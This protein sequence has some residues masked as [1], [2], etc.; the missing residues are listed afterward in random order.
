M[1]LLLQPTSIS[2]QMALGP[3]DPSCL[4]TS[5]PR[6]ARG[7]LCRGWGRTCDTS[8]GVQCCRPCPTSG[9]ARLMLKGKR[10]WGGDI[11]GWVGGKEG[12]GELTAPLQP[13]RVAWRCGWTCSPWTCQRPALPLI[14]P[15]G[16]RRSKKPPSQAAPGK[17]QAGMERW[18][19]AYPCS[20]MALCLGTPTTL[21]HPRSQGWKHRVVSSPFRAAPGG[22]YLAR[23]MPCSSRALSSVQTRDLNCSPV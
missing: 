8:G 5:A 14:F 10:S 2:Y 6:R 7:H 21:A 22:W 19:R 18:R 9:G 13:C 4:C 1:P 11:A 17:L 16:N 3:L 15:P 23:S 12:Q 20:S